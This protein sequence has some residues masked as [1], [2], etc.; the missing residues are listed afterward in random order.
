[1]NQP[2][3]SPEV[4]Q[5][6]LQ[7]LAEG[8]KLL[9]PGLEE[10]ISQVWIY[11]WKYI[12]LYIFIVGLEKISTGRIGSLFY[13]IFYFGILLIIIKIYG[14]EI[15]FSDLSDIIY[16]LLHPVAYYSTGLVLDKIKHRKFR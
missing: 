4:Y 14:L 15:L 7:A 13:N 1:M 16:A 5:Q 12:L 9:I 11:G 2:L 8:P 3:I 6:S 10:A